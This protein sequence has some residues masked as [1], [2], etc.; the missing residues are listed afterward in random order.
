MTVKFVSNY[1]TVVTAM[2][3][4]TEDFLLKLIVTIVICH[5]N[6]NNDK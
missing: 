6:D 4:M 1:M 2:T 3:V 5:K